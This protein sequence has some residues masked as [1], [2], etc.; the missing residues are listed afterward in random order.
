MTW[1]N[2]LS[3]TVVPEHGA[4]VQVP[5]TVIEAEPDAVGRYW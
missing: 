5:E 1:K 2:H 3:V 4:E